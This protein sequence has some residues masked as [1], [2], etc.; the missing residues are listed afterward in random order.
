[1]NR[2][3]LWCA[4]AV[5]GLAA[6]QEIITKIT[7]EGE[8]RPA[9]AVPDFRGAG[10]SA[11]YMDVFNRT[12]FADLDGSGMFRMV[13]K[14][15]YPLEVPQRPEDFRPPLAPLATKKGEP[16]KPVRQGPW[17]TDWSSPP[18]SAT[19]LA[20]GYAAVQNEQIVLS[21]WLYAVAQPN[22]TSAHLQGKR[23]RSEERRVGKECRL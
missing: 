22:I 8:S 3:I 5:A 9:L 10:Q 14:S 21:G 16:P 17:L 2:R 7:G 4:F 15:M 12:L 6:A 23:Y 1:M 11:A 18:V 19:H 20:F 13:A